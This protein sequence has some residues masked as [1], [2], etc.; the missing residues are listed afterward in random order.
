MWVGTGAVDAWIGDPIGSARWRRVDHL[1]RDGTRVV[2][3]TFELRRR[4]KRHD[5][6]FLHQRGRRPAFRRGHQI[7]RAHLVVWSPAAPVRQLRAPA[8][9]FRFRHD[10]AIPNLLRRGRSHHHRDH[11]RDADPH[12]HQARQSSHGFI[13]RLPQPCRCIR[14]TNVPH[15]DGALSRAALEPGCT[16]TE[17]RAGRK[18][19]GDADY[20]PQ[21]VGLP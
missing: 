10:W 1:P 2:D 16:R 12:E 6:P 9:V 21:Q 11:P 15:L 4:R 5:K 14:E 20:I 3:G 8:V 18:V 13:L 19:M 7:E 17:R